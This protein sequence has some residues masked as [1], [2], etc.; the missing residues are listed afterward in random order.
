[1]SLA[2]DRAYSVLGRPIDAGMGD[3]FVLVM[4]NCCL[5]DWANIIRSSLQHIRMIGW[6]DRG[7]GANHWAEIIVELLSLGLFYGGLEGRARGSFGTI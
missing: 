3:N 4:A 1:M 6:E 7:R 5:G 2:C